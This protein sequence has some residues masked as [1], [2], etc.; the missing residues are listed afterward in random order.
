MAGWL[1]ACVI[2]QGPRAYMSYMCYPPCSGFRACWLE[3][4]EKKRSALAS[5]A[6]H[7]ALPCIGQ[8][9]GSLCARQGVTE[10]ESET[11]SRGV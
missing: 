8:Y 2:G 10:T 9:P 3:E 11:R 5:D 7:A 1:A 6:A 4:E